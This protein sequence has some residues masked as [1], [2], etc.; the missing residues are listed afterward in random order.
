MPSPAGHILATWNDF[1]GGHWGAVGP[2]RAKDNQ[3]GGVNMIVTRQGFVVPVC[4][5]RVLTFSNGSAGKVWG[6]FWAWGLDGLCYFVQQDG[7]AATYTL[8]AFNPDPT[9]LPLAQTNVGAITG[10]LV[11]EPDWVALN[12]NLYVTVYGDKTY[13]YSSGTGSLGTLTGTAGNAAAGRAM[14]MYGERLLVG[15]VSD[16]RFGTVPNR[17]HFSGD[18]TNADPTARTVWEA[19][20]Y[21]DIGAAGTPIA[22]MVPTRDYL[23]V[24]LEDQ[25]VYVATGTF[26]PLGNVTVRRTSGFHKGS[27]AVE[28][29]RPSHVATDPAQTRVWMFDHTYRGPARFNGATLTRLREYGSPKANRTASGVVEGAVTA[30]GGPDEFLMH[31]VAMPR[32]AGEDVVS[33]DLELLR[34]NGLFSIVNRDVIAS[35]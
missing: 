20:N 27:G 13:V 22:A 8:K 23:V 33:A 3:Y 5:S 10:P 1:A 18:D 7:S 6:M 30:I 2:R 25:Q 16:A 12:D 19:T 15:G 29:L 34:M 11:Y 4:A 31:G 9:S 14:C 35:R 24:F 17:I 28:A 21:V 26:G 32:S